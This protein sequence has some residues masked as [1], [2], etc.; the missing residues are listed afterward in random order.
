[1]TL[2]GWISSLR[3]FGCLFSLDE[4]KIRALEEAS[5]RQEKERE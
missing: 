2:A 1:L 5:M 4:E 3:G